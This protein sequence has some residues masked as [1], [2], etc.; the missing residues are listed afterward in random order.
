MSANT[1]TAK[2]FIVY[3]GGS[4]GPPELNTYPANLGSA[5][6]ATLT[7]GLGYSNRECGSYAAWMVESTGG[8]MPPKSQMGIGGL[9]SKNADPSW[10]TTSPVPGVI[11][12]R[13]PVSPSDMGHVM[14]VLS[15]NYMNTGNLLVQAYNSNQAGN[16]SI[17]VWSPTGLF[18][19]LPFQLVYIQFPAA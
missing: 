1:N 17:E 9:W 16:F 11:A 6:Q 10:I 19:G 8:N 13:P 7:D 5:P 12:C 18:N 2:L 15:P 3:S 14:Y 4:V